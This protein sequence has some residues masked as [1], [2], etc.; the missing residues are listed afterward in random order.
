[1]AREERK[2]QRALISVFHKEGLEPIVRALSSLGVEIVSTG[3]TKDFIESLSVPVIGVDELTQYPHLLGGRVKTLHP[4]VFGGILA[5]R[6]EERDQQEVAEFDIRLFDLVIVDLYPFVQTLAS[7]AD[8]KA[9]IEKIDIGGIALIRAGAKNFKD[10]VIVPSVKEYAMIEEILTQREGVSTLEERK[11][12]ARQAF[13]VSSAYD[14]AIFNYFDQGEKSSLR[15]VEEDAMPLRYGENPHQKGVFFGDLDRFFDKIQGKEL[16][17]NNLQDVAAATALIAEYEEPT[18]AVLK[19][20][21]PCGIASAKNI[22]EAWV[23]ALA[24]DPESAFG[25]I[26]VANDCIDEATA[27][28]IG[29]LFFEVLI[30]PDFTPEALRLF[31]GK[32][33]RILLRQKAPIKEAYTF[34]SILGGV[35]MQDNDLRS[36]SQ[37][38][39]KT[40]TRKEPS[41]EEVRD[42]I[43]AQKV[44]K[45]CK[46]NAL[47]IV[48]NG[49]LLATGIGQTSRVAALKQAIE[50]AQHFGFDLE[51][52][53]LAS[54][55]F[56]PFDDCVSIAAQVGIRAIVQPGGSMRDQDSIKKADELGVAMVFTGI[57][58]FKH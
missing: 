17:Y 30:A 1:M 21:N 39:F 10:V 23:K 49:T 58:H 37:D 20:N 29:S 36:E 38:D 7:G 56:F 2:I 33:K 50:K 9:I 25:G 3:G 52:A 8:E 57:R 44:A 27:Q 53:V 26:L 45:H 5:R 12:F 22:Q 51:G 55:A 41:P 16:S 24:C 40:V 54:D 18:F 46:S 11:I 15:I 43:F 47:A 42:F 32:S 35:L 19:H 48:K 31:E 13:A 6:E 4:A 28:E 34:R 14:S